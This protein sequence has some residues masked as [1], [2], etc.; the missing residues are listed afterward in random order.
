MD[1][2]LKIQK[3]KDG[4]IGQRMTTIP[5]NVKH[6][7]SNNPLI[8]DF[9]ITAIGYYPQAI[10]HDRRRKSGSKEYILLYCIEGGG[11]IELYGQT[12]KLLTNSYIIIPPDESHHYQS[13]S[14]NP[15]TIYWAH[16]VGNKADV[17]FQRYYGNH[18]NLVRHIARSER[19]QNE[20][21]KIMNLL[22]SDYE[23]HNLEYANI[24][25]FSLIMK[26]IYSEEMNPLEVKTDIISK[27]IE[28]LNKNL[29]KQFK[30]EEIAYQ[31][32]LSVSRFS[33]LFKKKTGY[34][35]IQYFNKLKIQ[36]SCQYLYFTDM[37]IK[38]ICLKIG[39][40]DPYYYSRA[41]KKLM[42]KAPSMYRKEY[43]AQRS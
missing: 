33:E 7:I 22:E 13:S 12:H 5:P 35:P 32:N 20:L 2:S 31:Q 16:I 15:W 38:E 39:Y 40:D 28:F 27:S 24:S 21:I 1:Y 17:L 26:M 37:S 34:S 18:K 29:D 14:E 11:Q 6:D 3:I 19:R 23:P 36:K 30:V 25:L 41:F 43:K 42:G 9:Y 4:F 10:Y 8:N